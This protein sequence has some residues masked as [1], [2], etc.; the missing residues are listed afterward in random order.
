MNI[1][2]HHHLL[3]NEN[4]ACFAEEIVSFLVFT[5]NNKIIYIK[6]DVMRLMNEKVVEIF[7]CS[8]CVKNSQNWTLAQTFILLWF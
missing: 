4:V 5:K 6:I 2:Y 3:E 1:N 7:S 8:K